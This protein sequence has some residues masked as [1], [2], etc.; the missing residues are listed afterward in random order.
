MV[1]TLP[2]QYLKKKKLT[3]KTIQSMSSLLVM[4]KDYPSIIHINLLLHEFDHE[5]WYTF[6]HTP[7]LNLVIAVSAIM[8]KHLSTLIE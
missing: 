6:G 2:T 7:L 8:K 4:L 3:V 5:F 1:V